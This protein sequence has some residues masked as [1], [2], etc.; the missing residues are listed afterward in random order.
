MIKVFQAEYRMDQ[1]ERGMITEE[2]IKPVTED[3]TNQDECCQT[4]C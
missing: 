1:K 4:G 3:P 2:G